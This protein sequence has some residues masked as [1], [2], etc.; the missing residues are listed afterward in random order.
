MTPSV[1]IANLVES[2][3]TGLGFGGGGVS[4][5]TMRRPPS[6]SPPAGPPRRT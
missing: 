5:R 3:G 1:A 4:R 2:P 6:C